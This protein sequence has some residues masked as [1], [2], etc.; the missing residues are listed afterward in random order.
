MT[1]LINVDNGGAVHAARAV[2]RPE[3]DRITPRRPLAS[4]NRD[5]P[6]QQ[7]I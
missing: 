7:A 3:A 5:A 4:D 1:W 2:A 6:P